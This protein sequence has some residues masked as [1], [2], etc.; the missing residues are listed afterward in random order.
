MYGNPAW[1][2]FHLHLA[3]FGCIELSDKA[4]DIPEKCTIGDDSLHFCCA[5]SNLIFEL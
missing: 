3:W 1:M 2:E 4:L 5:S